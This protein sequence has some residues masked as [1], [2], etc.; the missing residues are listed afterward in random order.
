MNLIGSIVE[1]PPKPSRFFGGD[2]SPLSLRLILSGSLIWLSN[3]LAS[4]FVYQNIEEMQLI[5]HTR[6]FNAIGKMP[7][8]EYTGTRRPLRF[9]E[10]MRQFLGMFSY[11]NIKMLHCEDEGWAQPRSVSRCRSS[12]R[13]CVFPVRS[14]QQRLLSLTGGKTTLRH[15]RSSPAM[16]PQLQRTLPPEN[17][18][19]LQAAAMWQHNTR[20]NDSCQLWKCARTCHMRLAWNWQQPDRGKFTAVRKMYPPLNVVW[21][22]AAAPRT[23]FSVH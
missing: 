2:S 10:T 20:R 7:I 19:V 18:F 16:D 12:F 6:S 8:W 9:S 1:R 3:S 23:V 21:R 11:T 15:S 13:N 14:C 22:G 4:N 5:S 17:N